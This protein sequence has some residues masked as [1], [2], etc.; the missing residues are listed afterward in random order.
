MSEANERENKE[1]TGP[2]ENVE[3]SA[4]YFSINIME[5]KKQADAET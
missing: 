1:L 3:K 2:E 4:E 5:R